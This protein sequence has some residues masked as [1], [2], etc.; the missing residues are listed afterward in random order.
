MS[1]G[2]RGSCRFPPFRGPEEVLANQGEVLSSDL[3]LATGFAQLGVY[4]V[5]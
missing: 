5:T 2:I 4:L 1:R 3:G